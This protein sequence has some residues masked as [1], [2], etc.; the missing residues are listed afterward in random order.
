MKTLQINNSD[1]AQIIKTINKYRLENKNSWYQVEIKHNSIT[2]KIKAF[3]TWV[4]ILRA[5]NGE[6]IL[7]NDSSAMDQ[8]PTEFKEYLKSAI[9]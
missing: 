7:Y 1:K 4:Q 3:K 9:K 5:C 6:T 8:S 2:Y